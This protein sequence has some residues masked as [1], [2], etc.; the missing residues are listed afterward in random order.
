RGSA[1]AGVLA[2]DGAHKEVPEPLADRQ[3]VLVT[4]AAPA[5]AVL[6]QH[7]VLHLGGKVHYTGRVAQVPIEGVDPMAEV[8]QFR[9]PST[10]GVG[11]HKVRIGAATNAL[12]VNL[13]GVG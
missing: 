13:E 7:A 12:T 5:V 4:G 9:Y 11:D 10:L 6:D 8:V 3:D 1:G 2:V